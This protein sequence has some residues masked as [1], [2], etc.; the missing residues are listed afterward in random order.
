M[1]R[2]ETIELLERQR[3][4]T[5]LLALLDASENRTVSE[6][7]DEVGGSQSTGISRLNELRD[8]GLVKKRAGNNRI[9]YSLTSEG[10]DVAL[11]LRTVLQTIQ[12][13]SDENNGYD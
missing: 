7:L 4:I 2:D 13:A 12:R 11:Q 3:S 8:F 6:L 10:E 5:T 1:E 9:L